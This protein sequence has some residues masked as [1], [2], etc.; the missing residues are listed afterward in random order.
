MHSLLA[1]PSE[2]CRPSQLNVLFDCYSVQMAFDEAACSAFQKASS[3]SQLPTGGTSSSGGGGGAS[4]SGG[5]EGSGEPKRRAVESERR[6][7]AVEYLY[8]VVLMEVLRQ[9]AFYPGHDELIARVL[10]QCYR[11]FRYRDDATNV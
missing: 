11:R 1:V 7:L 9:Q 2:H 4:G 6:G 3:V 10:E 5:S 8:C